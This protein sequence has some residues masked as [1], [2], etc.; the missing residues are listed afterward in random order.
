MRSKTLAD[1]GVTLT[2]AFV[3]RKNTAGR[4]QSPVRRKKTLTS[5]RQGALA[6]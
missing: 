3:R 1:L 4:S 6:G 5:F 2:R